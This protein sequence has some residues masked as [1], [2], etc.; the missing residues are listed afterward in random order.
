MMLSVEA[1]P[2]IQWGFK[3]QHS[4]PKVMLNPTELTSPKC[5]KIYICI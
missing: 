2:D 4:N 5:Q 1:H 3:R